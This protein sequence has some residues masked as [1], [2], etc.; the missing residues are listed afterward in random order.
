VPGIIQ[1]D[2]LGL[3]VTIDDIEPVK[4]FQRAKQL[5]G[6]EPA[7]VLIKLSFPLQMV[8]EFS[9]IHETHH[10]VQFVGG[11]E[12][13]FEGD[14]EWVVH[15]SENGPLGKDVCNLSGSRGDVGLAD[16]LESVY[17]LSVFLPHLHHLSKRTLA[18]HLEEI[19][20]IDREGHVPGWLE[21]N[22]EVE[23][24]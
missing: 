8:E 24:T 18:D 10:E 14:D 9:A 16:S 17:P 11:L 4:M 2:I 21:I 23:G 20:S 22:L 19:E 3:Q 1:Q 6:I 7:P 5:G 13:K 15:Q 12:G